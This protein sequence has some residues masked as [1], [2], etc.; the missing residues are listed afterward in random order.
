MPNPTRTPK[1]IATCAIAGCPL[2]IRSCQSGTYA[3]RPGWR[4]RP[5]RPYIKKHPI[6]RCRIWNLQIVVKFE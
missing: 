4:N 2:H 5:G 6:E 1:L 3:T